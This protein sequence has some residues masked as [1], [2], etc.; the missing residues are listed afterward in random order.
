MPGSRILQEGMRREEREEEG[1]VQSGGE[2]NKRERDISHLAFPTTRFPIYMAGGGGGGGVSSGGVGTAPRNQ[3]ERLS[4]RA[5]KKL[6][7]ERER[8]SPIPVAPPSS[9]SSSFPPPPPDAE[10]PL[11]RMRREPMVYNGGS[12]PARNLVHSVTRPPL[13]NHDIYASP[14]PPLVSRL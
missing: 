12:L 9:S 4:L 2:K 6:R 13:L 3:K 5:R 8:A 14:S 7:E 1:R 11:I 10:V